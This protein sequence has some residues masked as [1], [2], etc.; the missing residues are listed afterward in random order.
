MPRIARVVIPG[1]PHH[2]TQRG[3][4]RQDVFFVADD[5]RVYLK[6]LRERSERFG[7]EVLGYCL[8]T[9]HIHLVAVPHGKS[10][11]AKAVGRT[12]WAYTQY[13]NELHARVGHLWHNRFY[14]CPTDEKHTV[15]ALRY[16]ECN[17]VRAKLVRMPWRYPWSSA[18]THVGGK[19][20]SELLD[21]DEW[22]KHWSPD[23]W[24]ET[25]REPLED[26]QVNALRRTTHRGRP[27]G[28]DSF[29]SKVEHVLGRRLRAR[30][31]GRPRKGVRK[32]KN[33]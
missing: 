33:R 30:P 28:S 25:L 16:V 22:R 3:N 6:L 9:N 11:L 20:R 2:V 27:L 8:M 13:V 31:V 24:R 4:N 21:L 5:Y 32:P 10:S 7:L 1:V 26:S 15:A 23:E 18:A 14:L 17:P 12:H 29:L 19:D